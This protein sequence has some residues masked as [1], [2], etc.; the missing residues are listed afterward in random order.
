LNNYTYFERLL[1][2]IAFSSNLFIEISF[3]L[4]NVFFLKYCNNYQDN[5]VFVTGLARSGTTV[6][7]NLIHETNLFGSLGYD[8][9]PFLLSPNLW[10]KINTNRFHEVLIERAHGD[11][12]KISTNS[13]EAFEELFWMNFSSENDKSLV[14]FSN[15]VRLILYR[16]GRNRYLS[17]NN[18]NIK[19][20]NVIQRC[21]PNSKILIPFRE[22][23]QH[24]NSLLTQHENFTIKQKDNDFFRKYMKWI[25][26]S[27]FGIDYKPIMIEKTGYNDFNELNHWLEQW[28]L[29]YNDLYKTLNRKNTMFICYED[30]CN[31]K[32]F[33]TLI[34][35]FIG[36]SNVKYFQ[37]NESYRR[38]NV[39][40]SEI[41]YK[42]CLLLYNNLREIL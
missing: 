37:F 40:Y 7:L 20:I 15:Y 39:A 42:K 21:F 26:H 14:H 23:L 19:R 22:P 3:D 25:G 27:E 36:I 24:S 8:D 29:I 38:I 35:N 30:L 12:M 4:E 1:H 11:G 10:S 28:Y 31:K 5:H 32:S 2:K 6:L 41:L 34:Q 13:P 17:K 33:W 9:M 16:K 18:Q